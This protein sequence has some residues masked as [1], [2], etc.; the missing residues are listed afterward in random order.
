M[1]LCESPAPWLH[2]VT[3]RN[4]GEMLGGAQPELL[5]A[6]QSWPSGPATSTQS[7][8]TQSSV[9]IFRSRSSH[10]CGKRAPGRSVGARSNAN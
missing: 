5:R 1:L 6:S 2:S 4:G 3:F 7:R 8:P 9:L 10:R